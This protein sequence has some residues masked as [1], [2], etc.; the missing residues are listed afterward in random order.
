VIA[1][2]REPRKKKA[3]KTAKENITNKDTVTG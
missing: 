1:D 2:A 3:K